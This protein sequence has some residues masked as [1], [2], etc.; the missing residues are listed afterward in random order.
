MTTTTFILP[1]PMNFPPPSRALPVLFIV[2][3]CNDPV[4]A[5]RMLDQGALAV[6]ADNMA[7]CEVLG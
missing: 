1:K 7:V 3:G 5:Q 4:V 6:G 2:G